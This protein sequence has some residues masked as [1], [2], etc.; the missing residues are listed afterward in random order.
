MKLSRASTYAFYG[1]AYIAAQEKD[2]FVPLSEIH[3]HRGVPEKHLAK[4]FQSLVRA[5]VLM[6]ARGVRGGFRLARPANEVSALDVIQ[7][8]E[9]PVAA[10]GCLLLVEACDRD[11]ACRINDIWRRAQGRMLEELRTAT[12]VDMMGTNDE[13]FS[14]PVALSVRKPPPYA[15][16]N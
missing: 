8:V 10:S 6:S 4:I 5:G 2:R 13:D 14:P 15:A 11:T 16:G 7:A 1:L 12:L 3:A 9:G